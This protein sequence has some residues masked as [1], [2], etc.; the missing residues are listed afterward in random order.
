MWILQ[1]LTG[2]FRPSLIFGCNQSRWGLPSIGSKSSG[3]HFRNLNN[4][5]PVAALVEIA[6]ASW[7]HGV[8]R[9]FEIERMSLRMVLELLRV[10]CV[11][12]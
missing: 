8:P 10:D 4:G 3:L 6:A 2:P 12:I 1:A 7:L 5:S 11:Q 9:Y